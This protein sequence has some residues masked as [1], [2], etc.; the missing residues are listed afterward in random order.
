PLIEDLLRLSARHLSASVNLSLHV[1]PPPG[2]TSAASVV[3][4]AEIRARSFN[5]RHQSLPPAF[6][7]RLNH[8]VPLGQVLQ[9]FRQFLSA[10]QRRTNLVGID[11]REL[12]KQMRP[13]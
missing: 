4:P 8:H 1:G 13:K 3:Q 10:V 9:Q 2:P 6:V 5:R 12:E 7:P 11:T